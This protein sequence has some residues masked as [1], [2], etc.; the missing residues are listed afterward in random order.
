MIPNDLELKMKMFTDMGFYKKK[1]RRFGV[2]ATT[3]MAVTLKPLAWWD[4]FSTQTRDLKKIS[5]RIIRSCCSTS[6]C[7]KN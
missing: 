2:D 6:S 7:E 4:T 3:R 5:T 1:A